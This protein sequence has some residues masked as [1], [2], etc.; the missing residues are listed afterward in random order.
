MAPAD[1]GYDK[2]ALTQK[3]KDI[4]MEVLADKDWDNDEAP[5]WAKAIQSQA[6]EASKKEG[7]KII[8]MAEVMAPGSGMAKSLMQ[9]VA[10]D[11]CV[12]QA[13]AKNAKGIT[14]YILL[15]ATKY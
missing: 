10:A 2:E 5:H 15:S 7:Y 13:E 14:S 11:D 4:S 9:L 3:L 12:V 6:F 8:C 1:E